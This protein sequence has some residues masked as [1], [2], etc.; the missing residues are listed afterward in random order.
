[1]AAEGWDFTALE[2]RDGL[3]WSWNEWPSSRSEA[4]KCVVPIGCLCVRLAPP[5]VTRPRGK[6][7]GDGPRGRATLASSVAAH[8]P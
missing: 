3:R 1:M 7:E 2:E 6:D 8:V 5:Q 4:S